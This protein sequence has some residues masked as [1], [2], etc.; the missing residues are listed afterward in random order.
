MTYTDYR[1]RLSIEISE[2]SRDRLRVLLPHGTQK[3]VF[4]LIISDL[5]EMLETHGS[6]RVIGA[7]IERDIKLKDLLKMEV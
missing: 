5:I 2:K 3:L 7:F 1:P 6:G 4:N